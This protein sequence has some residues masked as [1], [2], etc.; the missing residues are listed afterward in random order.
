[1][2][3]IIFLAAIVIFLAVVVEAQVCNDGEQRL[4]G[5]P[6]VGECRSGVQNCESGQWG[7]CLGGVGPTEEICHDNK[8]N[9]CNDRVDE[10]CE[11][12]EGETR[13]CGPE[14]E[15]GVCRFG[16]QTCANDA[17]GLCLNATHAFP[18]ELCGANGSG[19]GLDDD[20]NGQADEGCIVR[21]NATSNNCFNGIKDENEQGVDCGGPCRRCAT[22]DDNIQ[23]QNETGVDCGG[24]CPPCPG[25]EDGIKNQGEESVDC[26]GPCE[27][28]VKLEDTDDDHDG[29]AYSVELARGTD[30]NNAD[31]DGDGVDDKKDTMP[32]CPNTACD[33]RYGE[34]AKNCREDCG[35]K[36]PVA[37]VV[38]VFILLLLSVI[39]WR[40]YRKM[41]RRSLATEERSRRAP[42]IDV[43][44]Y[45]ELEGRLAKEKKSAME[46]RLEKSLKKFEKFMKK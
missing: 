2:R 38:I 14:Q 19:N 42:S 10:G 6:S 17:W 22:C 43:A 24:L 23:N 15:V 32:L 20:C 11:C 5:Y 34:T 36:R 31:T 12:R 1:M 7:I 39:G 46:D 26:G 9:N 4:C 8:D 44:K 33:V 13:T 45:K 28:C 41:S 40:L 27:P 18:N 3:L 25:C 30:P 16:R 29:W 37:T 35:T 21:T